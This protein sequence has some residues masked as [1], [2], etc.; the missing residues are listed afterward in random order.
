[1]RHDPAFD[2]GQPVTHQRIARAA[3]FLRQLDQLGELATQPVGPADGRA[4]VLE[5]GAAD[6]PA[7]P[8]LADLPGNRRLGIVEEELVEGVVALHPGHLAD[9]A[10]RDAGLGEVDQQVGDP[11]VLGRVGLGPHEHEHVRR[12][13]ALAGPYLLT[14]DDP[15][16]A[17]GRKLALGPHAGE[18]AART[19]LG[20]TLPPDVVALDG[21]SD[22]QFA[23]LLGA[24]FEER[25]HGHVHPVAADFHRRAGAGKFLADNLGLDHIDRLLAPAVA[26]GHRAIEEPGIDRPAAEFADELAQLALAALTRLPLIGKEHADFV[27]ECLRLGTV[28]QVHQ[29]LALLASRQIIA[30]AVVD[31]VMLSA[32]ASSAAS[33]AKSSA[34]LRLAFM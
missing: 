27:A 21:Q 1:M 12:L 34:L 2:L 31:S 4:L 14:V 29:G 3:H 16:A 28:T 17:I 19:R 13:A 15:L 32:S 24:L 11:V 6:V 25:R 18:I 26:L 33:K 23:L 10:A 8:A 5:R 7:L 9:R 30:V 20:I 22:E